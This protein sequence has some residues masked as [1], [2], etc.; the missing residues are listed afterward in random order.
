MS[1]IRFLIPALDAVKLTTCSIDSS[2]PSSSLKYRLFRFRIEIKSSGNFQY[3]RNGEC[4]FWEIQP[5]SLEVEDQVCQWNLQW[6]RESDCCC[7][8]FIEINCFIFD[9]KNGNFR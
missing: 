1:T 9:L 3:L 2:G 8:L 6:V 5:R 7:D 4:S